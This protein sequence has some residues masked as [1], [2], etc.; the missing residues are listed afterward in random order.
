MLH[1]IIRQHERLSQY[2]QYFRALFSRPQFEH[3]VIVLV[4]LVLAFFS[5]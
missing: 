4:A 2:L 3:F 1:P 5:R